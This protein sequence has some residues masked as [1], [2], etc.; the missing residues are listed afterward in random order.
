MD[1]VASH[2]H[3]LEKVLTP[4]A[5]RKMKKL[6]DE[7][8]GSLVKK[9]ASSVRAGKG[10]TFAAHQQRIVIAQLRQGQAIIAKR[11]VKD[12]TPLSVEAQEMSLRGLVTDVA[13]LSKY[14]TGAEV[15]L[16]VDA[17]AVF[18][19][20]MDDVSTSLL[21]VHESSMARYG[22]RIVEK[23]ENRMAL[24]MLQG[25]SSSDVIDDIAETIDGEWWQGERIVRSEMSRAR[26][27]AHAAGVEEDSKE[28][29]ELMLQ[30][31]EHCD[32]TGEPL[33][34]RVAVDSIAMHGQVSKVP[35]LFYMPA[36]A[37]FPDAK[38]NTTVPKSLVDA[39]PWD[40]AP[41]RPNGREILVGWMQEWG[42]PGW[43]WDGAGRKWLVR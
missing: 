4:K 33:D 32:E 9:L 41:C 19:G 30:W 14:Y 21:R 12:F 42:I 8:Q 2:R 3:A 17:A 6:Y 37:P 25:E 5:T 20:V 10:A 36:T 28:I 39:G 40:E 7:A 22:V 43:V 23:V 16:S 29:P 24:A 13:K 31:D 27:R 15:V 18:A 34:D 38:G 35:A 26:N 1:A 11:M